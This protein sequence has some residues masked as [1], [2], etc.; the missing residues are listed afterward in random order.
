MS[1]VCHN[2]ENALKRADALLELGKQDEAIDCLYDILKNRKQRLFKYTH[3]TTINKLLEICVERKLSGLAKDGLYLY[4][5][6]CQGINIK[7][8]EDAVKRLLFVVENKVQTIV[9]ELQATHID[10]KFLDRAVTPESLM[11][12][13][14][15]DENMPKL[16]QALLLP[17]IKF[18]WEC[19]RICLELLRN[20][21]TE[22]F[23]HFIVQS[24]FK[25]CLKYYRKNE[26]RKL[27]NLLRIHINYLQKRNVQLFTNIN[28]S[29]TTTLYLETGI[30]ELDTALELE[31]WH[32]AFKAIEDIHL[33]MNFGKKPTNS[34]AIAIYYEK[35]SQVFWKAD[36]ILYHAAALL[37]YFLIFR[38]VKKNFSSEMAALSS[39]VVLAVLSIPF[40]PSNSLIDLVAE[41]DL[42]VIE[43]KHRLLSSLLNISNKP[44]RKTLIKELKQ[45]YI[46]QS[47][48]Q[49]IQ[50]LFNALENEV[51]P[52]NI[53][54]KL[55]NF[56]NSITEMENHTILEQYF[57]PI[58]KVS[59]VRLLSQISKIYE[60]MTLNKFFS[61]VPFTDTFFVEQ[62]I[63][64][65]A[66]K[67]NILVK[68][69]H[70]HQCLRFNNG[71]NL[72]QNKNSL[73]GPELYQLPEN[74]TLD[75]LSHIHTG[76]KSICKL[77]RPEDFKL[78]NAATTLKVKEQY[79]LKRNSDRK[80]I[81]ERK[82]M[83]EKHKEMLENLRL[84]KEEQER[85]LFLE[86]QLKHEAAEKERLIKEAEK[87]A[88]QR[89]VLQEEEIKKQM[90]HEKMEY[91]KKSEF[92][93][94]IEKLDLNELA[95]VDPEK[96]LSKHIE[97]IKREKEIF[98]SRLRKQERKINH[99]ERAKRI[100]EIPFLEL[101]YQEE[102]V[103]NR[104]MWEQDEN[105][106]VQKF[107]LEQ[108]RAMENKERILTMKD[109][110]NEFIEK[111]KER[112]AFEYENNYKIFLHNLEEERQKRLLERKEQRKTERRNSWLEEQKERPRKRKDMQFKSKDH[113]DSLSN[114]RSFGE[115]Y[116]STST[117]LEY[118]KEF[119]NYTPSH[120]RYYQ[121][122]LNRTPN[123]ES[124]SPT[125]PTKDRIIMSELDY[126]PKSYSSRI[127]SS[128]CKKLQPKYQIL[129]RNQNAF[130]DD[131]NLRVFPT[132][133][134]Q[135]RFNS[136][137]EGIGLKK[138]LP[139]NSEYLN[140]F[141]VLTI[142]NA[143]PINFPRNFVHQE[144]K[145]LCRRKSES[146]NNFSDAQRR[147]ME[148]DRG[149]YSLEETF[150]GERNRDDI[151]EKLKFDKSRSCT[152]WAKLNRKDK[153][154]KNDET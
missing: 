137:Y 154:Q 67:Y 88:Y 80:C 6:I 111:V 2:P 10:I 59:T 21:Q 89:R 44:T 135:E 3:E 127:G 71:S 106:R 42:T 29:E 152:P 139:E 103:K 40:D 109:D 46:L 117:K 8:W 27:C 18:M 73:E 101:Q 57:S 95:N 148:Y 15:Y 72:F 153:P 149:R 96:L 138:S 145:D 119:Q 92:G 58:F 9:E 5:I 34:K 25:F 144:S 115:R 129:K 12:I 54:N 23:Y 69:D 82:R 33:L 126:S 75:Y 90:L 131:R 83:I 108:S 56:T 61:L 60:T 122:K 132:P 17:W 150:Y 116:L 4:R 100:E 113:D 63:V 13:F 142:P 16:N 48:P 99:M 147:E 107:Y 118:S 24:A 136:R 28:N 53:S 50:N 64:D 121:T 91:L 151:D 134:R 68:I 94:I 86:K 130:A 37:R 133:S 38:E 123:Q 85:Q 102:K 20:T 49:N 26:F 45:C 41:N 22:N 52:L 39:R 84:R 125:K 35:L 30:L 51:D 62:L 7:S 81:F 65:S 14:K 36:N 66:R 78:Q 146:K 77:I 140:T 31:L 112:N 105:R 128:P 70:V 87:R 1:T 104:N 55:T 98:L 124:D 79:L 120:R 32:E 76:L 143:L 19:Y 110:L 97:Q 74:Q 114:S 93:Q 47:S 11:K 141:S 43:K